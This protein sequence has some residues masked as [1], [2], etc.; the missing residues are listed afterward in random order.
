MIRLEISADPQLASFRNALALQLADLKNTLRSVEDGSF[1]TRADAPRPGALIH[2]SITQGPKA[3]ALARVKA[4]RGAFLGM[5][6]S[7]IDYLNWMIALRRI[8]KTELPVPNGKHTRESILEF[9]ESELRR[10]YHEVARDTRQSNPKKLGEFPHLSP[11]VIETAKS[12][13]A[14]RRCLEHHGGVPEDD[15]PVQLLRQAVL[16]GGRE[17]SQL[18]V[19]VDNERVGIKIGRFQHVFPAKRPI[20]L[21]EEELERIYFTLDLYLGPQVALALEAEAGSD[22]AS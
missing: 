14:L 17:I 21:S 6:R 16:V 12:F 22:S 7:F 20:A 19:F 8:A 10:H 13:F 11:P 9:V 15:L 4:T 1:E 5:I 18:P 3:N 2:I